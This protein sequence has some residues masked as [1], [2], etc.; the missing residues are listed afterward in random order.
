MKN[1]VKVILFLI[2]TL[3]LFSL[4]T[5]EVFAS[6]NINYEPK[7]YCELNVED[8]FSLDSVLVM[9]DKNLSDVNKVFEKSFFGNL[10]IIHIVIQMVHIN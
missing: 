2:I 5:N 1:K 10:D 8:D 9:I 7:I 6:E 4:A 3:F